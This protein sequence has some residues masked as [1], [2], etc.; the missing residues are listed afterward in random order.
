MILPFWS[1]IDWWHPYC[2]AQ[3]DG[4]GY[5]ATGLPLPLAMPT[6]AG[7]VDFY[8]VPWL[9]GADA[10]IFLVALLL[11]AS[12]LRRVQNTTAIWIARGAKAAIACAALLVLLV[13]WN[14]GS[15]S[16]IGGFTGYYDGPMQSMRPWFW[17]KTSGHHPCSG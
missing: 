8:V 9:L 17:A 7:S 1:A 16:A 12:L 3:T 15:Y 13:A 2:D 14:S 11:L 10:L 6:G 4:P 5:F